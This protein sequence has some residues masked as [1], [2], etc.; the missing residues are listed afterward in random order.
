MGGGVAEARDLEVLRGEVRDRVE[1]EIDEPEGAV[2]PCRR[3]VADRH[4]DLV[5]VRLRPELGNHRLGQ[6]D[7]RHPDTAL[8]QRQRDSPRADGELERGAAACELREEV[9]RRTEHVRVVHV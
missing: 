9:D 2:D 3:D 8:V 1:H 6:I 4:V 5:G 7:P